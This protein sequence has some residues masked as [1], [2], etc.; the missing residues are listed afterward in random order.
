MA[1]VC[2]ST[3]RVRERRGEGGAVDEEEQR[4][5]GVGEVNLMEKKQSFPINET[6]YPNKF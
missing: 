3:H 1:R 6:P 4:L 2:G 5:C